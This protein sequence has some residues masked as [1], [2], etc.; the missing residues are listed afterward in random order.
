MRCVDA[1]KPVVFVATL[2]LAGVTVEATPIGALQYVKLSDGP[3]N[4]GGGEFVI[5]QVDAQGDAMAS[6][7]SFVTFCIQRTEYIDFTHVFQIEGVTKNA[8]SDPA[9]NGGVNDKDPIDSRTAYLYSMFRAG[10]LPNYVYSTAP[11]EATQHRDSANQ[12]QIAFWMI[13]Q[14]L[15]PGDGTGLWNS[16]NPYFQLANTAIA[17]GAWSGIGNVRA[18]NLRFGGL[19][20]NEAQDQLALETPE[21]AS[22]LLFGSG[23]IFAATQI[24]RR[25]RSR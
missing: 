15:K 2:L 19:D 22:L 5:T 20:G 1:F 18:L 13:E 3:G 12:L 23:L 11:A 7:W 14:E 10:S 25:A 21:P 24:R 8:V 4:T 6:A 16:S 9:A 17:T